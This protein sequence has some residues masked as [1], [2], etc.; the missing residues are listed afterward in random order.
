MSEDL[1]PEVARL[2]EDAAL[3]DVG[4]WEVISTRGNDRV[5]F[6]HRVLTGR[7]EGVP[8]GQGGRTMLLTT[9]GHIVADL[10]FFI[11]PEE[12]RLVVPP[13]QGAA[14]AAA[15]G[16]Y[17]IMDDF[18]AQPAPHTRLMAVYGPRAAHHLRAAG[19]P[20]PEGFT[21]AERFA[22]I[23]TDGPL[24]Q[25]WLIRVRGYGVEGLW[26]FGS[27]AE[28]EVLRSRLREG[29]RLDCLTYENAEALRILAGEP[30]FGAEITADYFPMEV[31]RTAAV[32][33]GKGCFLGQEP[34][35]RIRDRGHINWRLVGLRFAEGPPV[36]A[37]DRL[38]TE[39]KPRAG[40]VTSVA[41]LPDGRQV[42]LGL[43]H[44]SIPVGA[45]VSLR[46]GEDVTAKATVVAVPEET[47]AAFA[48]STKTAK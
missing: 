13:G 3:I 4:P 17:A 8:P 25:L 29:A 10:L 30:R 38:T 37:G 22:H 12:V 39:A 34:I 19:V 48:P 32:D 18:S 6:L 31:G 20:L 24:G 14:T 21:Q 2:R 42:A 33:Y 5:G 15:L 9:K 46:Q 28:V 36:A 26:V 45:E 16:R 23:D 47:D 7:I 40:R 44:V 27:A 43:L 1:G 35:V 41:R 11:R